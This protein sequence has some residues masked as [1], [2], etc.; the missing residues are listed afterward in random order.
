MKKLI[1]KVSFC[2]FI[3]LVTALVFAIS[4]TSI[5]SINIPNSIFPLDKYDQNINTWI[6]PVD[7]DYDRPLLQ[8]FEQENFLKEYYNH[9][10]AT[11]DHAL[12]PWSAS[13]V[14]TQIKDIQQKQQ[15]T[16]DG[17]DNT[18][19]AELRK[20]DHGENY[21]PYDHKW[22]DAIKTN[23]NLSQFQPEISFA[24]SNCGIAIKN[25]SARALPTFDP[26]F[27]NRAFITKG[28]PF[29]RLQESAIWVGTPVYIIGMT[30]DQQWCLV[31]TPNGFTAWVLSDGVAKTS[32][33]FIGQW[34]EHA[35]KHLA[36]IIKTNVSIYSERKYK[37]NAYVGT[38]FPAK[39][40]VDGN[41]S[42]ILIPIADDNGNAKIVTATFG[43]SGDAVLMPFKA[44]PH[45][46]ATIIAALVGRP[47]GWGGMYFYNDCSAELQSLYAPFGIWLPRNTGDQI[48]YNGDMRKIID[49]STETVEDR[50]KHL[51]K[52]G[53]KLTTI[54][55]V[56][57]HVM[58][59]M[60]NYASP[61]AQNEL[62]AMT[63][64]NTWGPSLKDGSGCA[65][66]GKS[67]FFPLLAQ[68]SEDSRLSSSV[69]KSNFKLLF[70][71]NTKDDKEL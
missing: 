27:Y 68:Y 55:Y 18:V 35:K 70:L 39:T 64:Q 28:Y 4:I 5:F 62:V 30:L 42:E 56:N 34:Q 61:N 32:A 6:N 65:I 16:I 53:K 48:S 49:L 45:N 2:V 10:Y 17:Y 63:Y 23:I 54:I 44:T 41:V 13:Y 33:D 52:N 15:A 43:G 29:D 36:A 40:I 69:S 47:Y 20:N 22:I 58:L 8:Q 57:G 50:L 59:Y 67:V 71:G 24:P 25:L 14:I 51:I 11:D 31:L 38:I 19:N 7:K 21:R 3:F 46:F 37:F 66:I 9:Y 12:S 1:R 60:G 26:Y